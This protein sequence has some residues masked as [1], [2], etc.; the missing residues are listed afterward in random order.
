MFFA[1]NGKSDDGSDC[2]QTKWQENIY[3]E[4]PRIRQV[5]TGPK[6]KN[7]SSSRKKTTEND[8]IIFQQKQLP[9]KMKSTYGKIAYLASK[10][11]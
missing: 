6:R 1:E 11:L 8:K 10:L 5:Q 2:E 7:K 9:S 3:S 4:R